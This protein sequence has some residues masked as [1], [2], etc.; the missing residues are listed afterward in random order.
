MQSVRRRRRWSSARRSVQH[1]HADDLRGVGGW[2]WWGGGG[3]GA[4]ETG[5]QL[6]MMAV[7]S[8]VALVEMEAAAA[9][10]RAL[11]HD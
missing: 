6:V 11:E 5:A 8:T 2:G 1:A 10:A 4:L 7:E 9:V 3:G